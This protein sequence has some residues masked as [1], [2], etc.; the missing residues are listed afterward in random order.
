M[1]RAQR[2]IG[3][4]DVS[5]TRRVAGL[6]NASDM[7]RVTDASDASGA[8]EAATG[9]RPSALAERRSASH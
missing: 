3:L 1:S 2:V 6:G 7:K 8:P 4:G 9:L 5:D